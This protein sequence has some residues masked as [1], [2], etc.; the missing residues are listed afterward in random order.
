MNRKFR[1]NEIEKSSH[2]IRSRDEEVVIKMCH[3]KDLKNTCVNVMI[4]GQEEA[5]DRPLA[6]VK[7]AGHTQDRYTNKAQNLTTLLCATKSTVQ[8]NE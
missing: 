5:K 3:Q 4:Q 7:N 8:P 1:F 2:R 6:F